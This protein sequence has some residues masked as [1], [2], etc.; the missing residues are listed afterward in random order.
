MS[1]KSVISELCSELEG[2]MDIKLFLYICVVSVVRVCKPLIGL[3]LCRRP[4]TDVVREVDMIDGVHLFYF[5]CLHHN[6]MC[7]L[8]SPP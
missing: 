2:F 3:L 4:C 6:G 1:C 5:V 7:L 8:K